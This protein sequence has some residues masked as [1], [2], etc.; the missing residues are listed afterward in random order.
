MQRTE[1]NMSDDSES[2]YSAGELS[3]GEISGGALHKRSRRRKST[4]KRRVSKRTA[5]KKKVAS[6]K[7]TS[8]KKASK[9][10]ASKKKASKKIASKKKA[11]RKKRVTSVASKKASKKK[12]SRKKASKKKAVSKSR[13]RSKSKPRSGSKKRATSKSRSRSKS[14]PRSSSKK[15]SSSKSRSVSKK[16]TNSKPRSRSRSKP[17][18]SS[19]KRA[20]SKPRSR[21][22]SKPRA[23]SRSSSAARQPR[24]AAPSGGLLAKYTVYEKGVPVVRDNS[25]V[26][27]RVRNMMAGKVAKY[28]RTNYAEFKKITYKDVLANPDLDSIY[29]QD[30]QTLRNP[31]VKATRQRAMRYRPGTMPSV[32]EVKSSMDEEQGVSTEME[33]PVHRE[34]F[35]PVA[36]LVSEGNRPKLDVMNDNDV[37]FELAGINQHI[38]PGILDEIVNNPQEYEADGLR[39]ILKYLRRYLIAPTKDPIDQTLFDKI[40]SHVFN[41]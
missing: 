32:A 11:S 35:D 13:S 39:K 31:D 18:S 10:R 1:D 25:N 6:K 33:M 28:L 29:E 40:Y 9:K 8:R 17:R 36:Y 20:E 30:M 16:R 37:V 3:G 4:S 12:A 27:V 7:K 23:N 14:K 22:T 41:N 24:A 5:T 38:Y 15:R 2:E 21:S 26:N 34:P 19:K